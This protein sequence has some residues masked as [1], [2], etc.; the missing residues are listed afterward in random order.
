MPLQSSLLAHLPD[1]G[2]YIHWP[3]CQSKCP[4]CDFNSHVVSSIDHDAWAKAYVEEIKRFGALTPDRTLKSVFFG[5]GTP[6]LMD[7][8]V[9]DAVLN[10]IRS[11]WS[12]A[13]DWEVTL[14]ANPTSV[15]ASRFKDYRM[16]GVNRISMGIQALNDPDLKRLGRLHSVAEALAA[17]D[18]ARN[19]FDRV[20]FDLIY[21]RQDQTLSDWEKELSSALKMAVDHL[22][23]YQLTIE[24]GTAFGER[25]A[26]GGLK[27]LPD[28]DLGADMYELT[29]DLCTAAGMP[30]YEISNHAREGAQSIHNLIYW[31][32]G[33]Y[34]GIGPGAHGRLTLDDT[35][36]ATVAPSQPLHWLKS[37]TNLPENTTN[38]ETIPTSD[39]RA[40]L[41]MMGL[42]VRDGVQKTQLN[43][44][45]IDTALSEKINAL[46]DQG[47]LTETETNIAATE[48][49]RMVL[50]ELLRQLLAD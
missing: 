5:G 17:F 12:V 35:R 49:G 37:V 39:Q 23:L 1:F 46:V 6:S 10:A 34:V 30:A 26:A 22:S 24:P 2:I 11:T 44:T 41:L 8:S 43:S 47:M 45:G 33:D 36:Y 7:P 32:G 27:G 42:R 48:T 16:S 9:V 14:E 4:Y 31:T 18:I 29:Q 3:F 40:E 19:E 50:N 25:F 21:A 13:N 38:W 28:E 20:S 15:E